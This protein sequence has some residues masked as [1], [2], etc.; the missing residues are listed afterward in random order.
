MR[1][2]SNPA[3]RFLSEQYEADDELSR[4]TIRVHEERAK[5]ILSENSSPDL[6][7]RWSLNPYRGCFHACAYCYA[8]PTHEYWG[9]GAG[10]D[11]ES[12]LIVKVNA[13]ELLRNTFEK[14]SWT[15]DLV[16]FSG[17][18]DCY[19]PLEASWELTRTCL[20]ICRDYKNPVGIITKS[21]LIKRDV[22]LL[23]QL[24][25]VA[26]IR[27]YLSIPF[28]TDEIA[29]KVEPQAPSITKRFEALAYLSQNGIP[30]AVSLA[31][32]IPGLN[33][34][35]IPQILRRARDSGAE[36]ATYS[37]LRLNDT[38]EPVFF[39]RMSRQFPERIRKINNR[40]RETRNHQVS[41]KRYFARH[42]G[43]G[44]TW[45]MIEHLF[46]LS[47]RTMGY[48]LQ[49]DSPVLKTFQRPSPRQINLF[50]D[51]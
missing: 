37:L 24:R 47:Y 46:Q 19:Q 21:S 12:Q 31:P 27:V 32:I 5:T 33:E 7:F 38:V 9:Y 36:A 49:P 2:V 28:A 23:Q 42:K 17:N 13:P 8:R 26:W 1:T 20:K 45:Q 35:D 11:F 48:H 15:G 40:L 41:E 14:P 18:T 51:E 44:P 22:E 4:A 29:R 39:E 6:P 25:D 50:P 34:Q 43:D 16:V 3:N 30:T 10:T